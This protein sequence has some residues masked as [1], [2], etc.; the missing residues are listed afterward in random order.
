MVRASLPS[1]TVSGRKTLKHCT[2]G[3]PSMPNITSD[4]AAL[5]KKD[6]PNVV[7]TLWLLHQQ[8]L[9]SNILPTVLHEVLCALVKFFNCVRD[10]TLSLQLF[11]GFCLE[12]GAEYELFV[13]YIEVCWFSKGQVSG[14]LIELGARNLSFFL[15]GGGR[16]RGEIP[17]LVSFDLV[18]W[19]GLKSEGNMFRQL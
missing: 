7:V 18:G 12:M 10:I 6:A 11:K 8:V 9:L 3:A 1:K 14:C 2:E 13:Y 16:G 5:E 15:W 19:F 4:Y 17:V